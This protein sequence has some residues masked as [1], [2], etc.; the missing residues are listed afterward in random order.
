[1][2]GHCTTWSGIWTR[3]DLAEA[4]SIS[5][6]VKVGFWRPYDLQ[7]LTKL[8]SHLT[9]LT[10]LNK[11]IALRGHPV[12]P[13]W[14]CYSNCIIIFEPLAVIG[15]L[16]CCP[17]LFMWHV[18]C[19][20]IQFAINLKKKQ[21]LGNY[22]NSI[23]NNHLLHAP[24]VFACVPGV[25]LQVQDYYDINNAEAGLLQTVFIISYMLLSP[26]FGY[27]GDR[28]NRKY[29]MAIGIFFWA[30]ITLASS[31]IPHDVSLFPSNAQHIYMCDQ[32]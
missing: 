8:F 28:Y 21:K 27:L 13:V 10:L 14:A 22:R 30:S 9:M 26:L 6:V 11:K 20:I 29:L 31:F 3:V 19:Q 16:V 12:E 32:P 25:L 2:C 1:M 18:F 24:V 7:G 4:D 5:L 17:D 15:N 23:N